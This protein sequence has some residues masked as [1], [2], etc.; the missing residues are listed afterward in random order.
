MLLVQGTEIVCRHSRHVVY[1]EPEEDNNKP[2]LGYSL[3]SDNKR[4]SPRAMYL[5]D[6]RFGPHWV[7]SISAS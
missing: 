6:A 3:I 2:L 1:P 7:S 4:V 5:L